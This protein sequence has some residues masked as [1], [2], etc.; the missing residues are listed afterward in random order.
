MK[1]LSQDE[2]H[3]IA[4]IVTV[5]DGKTIVNN[6]FT[7]SLTGIDDPAEISGDLKEKL[8]NFAKTTIHGSLGI[9]DPDNNDQPFIVKK[10][11]I[12]SDQGYG[13]IQIN[14]N[15]WSYTLHEKLELGES[16]TKID[17][18]NVQASDGSNTTITITIQ[19]IAPEETN[20]TKSKNLEPTK[21]TT[22]DISK[23]SPKEIPSLDHAY[24][25]ELSAKQVGSLS[26]KQFRAIQK[27]QLCS[28]TS[29]A[30]TGMRPHHLKTL[31]PD[32][33]TTF[34]RKQLKAINPEHIS[35]IKC[36]SL[37]ALGKHQARAFTDSQLAAM[38]KSQQKC[39]DEFIGNLSQKQR[40]SLGS[41]TTASNR[42]IEPWNIDDDNLLFKATDLFL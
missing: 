29:D 5:S 11:D 38:S 42:L 4:F 36:K 39:A 15:S 6:R 24:F 10:T 7:I 19:G 14:D 28:L 3:D 40:Q 25:S 32:E 13:T 37:N 31:S 8:E 9:N 20:A 18:F 21:P 30:V 22:T 17:T 12:A 33:L 1:S 16:E 35:A 26:T 2:Q 23:L 34:H 41:S 27:F